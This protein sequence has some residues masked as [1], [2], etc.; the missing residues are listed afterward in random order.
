MSDL[1]NRICKRL[2]ELRG[3]RS[4]FES[5]WTE[6]Y[7]YGAPERQQSF[8]GGGGLESTREKQRAD[9]LDSTAS[10]SV[11]ILVS[12]LIAGTTPANAQWFKAAPDGVDDP[13]ALTEGEHWLDQVCQFIFRNIHGANFDSEVFDLMLDFVVAGWAVMYQDIDRKAGG[14]YTFQ[15]W[16]IGECFISSTRPDFIVDTIYREYMLS[17]SQLVAQ[18]GQHKVSSAVQRAYE[19]NP[20]QRF[21]IVHVIEPRDIKT[22]MDGRVLLPKQMPFASYHVEVDAK[23]I[24][25]ESG[26]NEFPCAVPRFRKLPGSV[27]GIGL[28]S[29]A[30][31]DAKTANALVRDTVR[32]AEI[33]VLGMWIAEDDGVLNPRTVRL[34]GGK[35]ITANSVDSMKR[36]DSGKGFQ[37]GEK[38]LDRLQTGIRRKLMADSMTSPYGQPMTAAETYM[39]VDM[40]R[41]QIGPLYGRAQSEF[42][43][44]I[45]DRSFGLAYRASV[46]GEAPEDIQGRSMSFKFIS[47]LARSQQLEDV[48]AIERLMGSLGSVLEVDP[49][50]LDNVDTSAMVQVM[51]QRLG[52]PTAIMRT[53]DK[54]AEYRQQKAQQQ[55]QAQ[56]QQAVV[57]QQMGGAVA[58]GL[59]AQMVSEVMQ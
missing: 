2:G 19:S 41:Q 12:N 7:K 59:E 53:E 5:H 45:L 54:L 15:T 58:K 43:I 39:R 13:S 27:Y 16:P 33:D 4:K 37:I 3:E 47:P 28:M 20:D 52:V 49:D 46:L 26:Y 40:I 51:A 22:P 6:C 8:S 11:L 36:M 14:G 31:P 48:G 25:K 24:L 42:L 50:A 17:A 18:F 1:A 32:S 30:L 44:P 56:E 9:L 10:E 38:L 29:T 34:G 35:I 57:A 21:K 55:A 23:N